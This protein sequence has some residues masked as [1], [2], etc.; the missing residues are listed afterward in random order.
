M[1]VLRVGSGAAIVSG[2]AHDLFIDE[3]NVDPGATPLVRSFA[4]N[5]G[6]NPC[7]LSAGSTTSWLYDQ[8]GI[9]TLSADGTFLVFPCYATAAGAQ[10]TAGVNKVAGIVYYTAGVDT[11]T[12]VGPSNSGFMLDGVGGST[13]VPH[14]LRSIAS[15]GVSLW[16]GSQGYSNSMGTSLV[17]TPALGQAS[18]MLCSGQIGSSDFQSSGCLGVTSLLWSGALGVYNGALFFSDAYSTGSAGLGAGLVSFGVSP[19]TT[20]GPVGVLMAAST[21]A[22]YAFVFAGPTDL[23]MTETAN[24][25][26]NNIARWT[27]PTSTDGGAWTR[28]EPTSAMLLEAGAAIISLAGRYEACGAYVLYA[29]S[30]GSL[31]VYNAGTDTATV[32]ALAPARTRFR[33]VTLAPAPVGVTPVWPSCTATP[34]QTP[35]PSLT[36]A[37]TTTPSPT[38]TPPVTASHTAPATATPSSSSVPTAT[39]TKSFGATP[40]GTG[41]KTTTPTPSGAKT[42]TPVPTSSPHVTGTPTGTKSPTPTPTHSKTGSSAV[43][44]TATG[45]AA[46]T[47]SKTGTRSAAVTKTGTQS[48]TKTKTGTPAAT[49]S[50]TGTAAASKSAAASKTKTPAVRAGGGR[51]VLREGFPWCLPL[52]PPFS[53]TLLPFQATP[54][55]TA[56]RTK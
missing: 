1:A 51:V 17:Y 26:V 28:G 16:W 12:F 23:W 3:F 45:S 19:P 25:L 35:T 11:S 44:R 2:V 31:Y 37:L 38:D 41:A 22:P 32:V 20:P 27:G 6:A 24:L 52:T 9:P 49:R 18:T 55:K 33:G 13:A 43:T 40:T 39:P 8:E 4:V 42:V 21:N 46:V 47:R 15:D 54:S 10:L 50:K 5:V 48:I 53:P 7:R 56:T 30:G 14:A 34:T 29:T 36:P